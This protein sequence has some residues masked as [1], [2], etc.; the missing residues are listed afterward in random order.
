MENNK[1]RTVARLAILT[2]LTVTMGSLLRLPTPTGMVT[3]LDAGVF[4]TAFYWGKRE[5]AIVGGLSGFL[6]DLISGYPQ[7]MLASLLNHGLQGYFA[8]F[9]GR[10]FWLGQ[11]LALLSMVGGYFL[12]SIGMHGWG[13][14]LADI[15]ANLM[16]NLVG[17]GLGLALC[18]LLEKVLPKGRL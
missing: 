11:L 15:P 17:L 1:I 4:L 5:G 3:L 2:A 12:F 8:G 6:I 10:S 9:K 7:W 16:Q 13:A 18:Q 14:A